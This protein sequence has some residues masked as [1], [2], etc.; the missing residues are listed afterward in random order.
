MRTQAGGGQAGTS[1]R[2][3][4]RPPHYLPASLLLPLPRQPARLAPGCRRRCAARGRPQRAAA[5]GRPTP[6]CGC[7]PGAAAASCGG[8]SPLGRSPASWGQSSPAW[9]AGHKGRGRRISARVPAR[10][11]PPPPSHLP[12][13]HCGTLSRGSV[14]PLQTRL[15]ALRLQHLARV[16][17]HV[18]RDGQQA[19]VVLGHHLGDA[20]VV[21][22]F[23]VVHLLCWREGGGGSVGSDSRVCAVPPPPP[24]PHTASAS[25]TAGCFEPPRA[26]WR[27]MAM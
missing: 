5:P 6:R 14:S 12:P 17:A 25:S 11:Q 21:Q 18:R 27:T 7:R 3:P 13:P 22:V 19:D 24:P 8:G 16:V 1:Q 10:P 9:A 2:G 4:V 23:W 15:H 26:R 20:G